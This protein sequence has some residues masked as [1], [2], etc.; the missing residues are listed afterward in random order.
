M[1]IIDVREGWEIPN[2]IID[3]YYISRDAIHIFYGFA[4]W[5]GSP[6]LVRSVNKI[7]IF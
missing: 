2:N 5:M 7:L 1:W 4:R 6:T 3:S